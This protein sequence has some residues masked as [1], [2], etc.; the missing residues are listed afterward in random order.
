MD[1]ERFG[2]HEDIVLRQVQG[3]FPGIFD[4][5]KDQFGH[6][7]DKL[8]PIIV[9]SLCLCLE[10]D[11]VIEQDAVCG[12]GQVRGEKKPGGHLFLLAEDLQRSSA[13]PENGLID[14]KNEEKA[15]S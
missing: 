3:R 2:L 1:I 5:E 13:R 7:V 12:H 10:M 8:D 9:E 4:P 14:E 11:V 6:A 15:K